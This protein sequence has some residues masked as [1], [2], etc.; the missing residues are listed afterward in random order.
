MGENTKTKLLWLVY[1]WT[2]E[3]VRDSISV[4]VRSRSAHSRLLPE[5]SRQ[6]DEYIEHIR[7]TGNCFFCISRSDWV[8]G[9]LCYWLGWNKNIS[10]K[11]QFTSTC[12][13][14]TIWLWKKLFFII[15]LEVAF[16]ESSWLEGMIALK[17]MGFADS[18]S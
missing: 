8:Q 1:W 3:K 17:R 6:F 9:C 15:C 2:L 7:S 5:F 14:K 11:T 4:S 16:S 10:R 13:A 18:I 12:F